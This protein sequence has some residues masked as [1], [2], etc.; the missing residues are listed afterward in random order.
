MAPTPIQ[1]SDAALTIVEIVPQM[2]RTLAAELR[3]SDEILMPAH[4]GVL[5]TLRYQE[6]CNVSELA[7][8][9]SV[10]VPTMSNLV[11]RMVERGWLARTRSEAD[12]RQVLLALTPA[13]RAMV[14]DIHQQAVD[15]V[16][17]MLATLSAG[18]RAVLHAGLEVLRTVLVSDTPE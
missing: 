10:T 8:H 9:L 13:G 18:E 4:F 15:H 7:E 3:R 16:D 2:M 14:D 12:R 5:F 6:T 1:G 17:D 11:A